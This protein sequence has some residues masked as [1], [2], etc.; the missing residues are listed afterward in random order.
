MASFIE[1]A[2]KDTFIQALESGDLDTFATF[3]KSD[4]HNHAGRGGRLEYISR[5]SSLN[6]PSTF[7]SLDEMDDWLTSCVFPLLPSGKINYL[8]RVEG[9]LRAA[10]ADNI[11]VLATNFG[12]NEPLQYGGIASF[13]K[14]I[15]TMRVHYAPK[16]K[17]FPV[18][19]IYENVDL[20]YIKDLFEFGWFKAID[21]INYRSIMSDAE[22][23]ILCALARNNGLRIRSHVGE[24]GSPEDVE[25]HILKYGVEEI[26][27]G[28]QIA[29]SRRVMR[30]VAD[31]RIPLHLCPASNIGL[32]LF[33]N[34]SSYPLAI[35]HRNGVKVTINTDDLLV[36][37]KSVSQQFLDLHNVMDD[38]ISVDDLYEI[39]RFGLSLYNDE[40]S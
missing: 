14:L 18:A 39:Y 1:P 2:D 25:T 4:L 20:D 19:A 24:F 28:I 7:A 35:L 37:G 3:Q 22:I 31:A 27:H 23:E 30:L 38:N 15:D 29:S 17:L 11:R 8:L 5:A 13:A 12:I 33:E 40:I 9:T 16:T 34:Y 26:Q 10:C 32:G 36:F 21:I 6:A